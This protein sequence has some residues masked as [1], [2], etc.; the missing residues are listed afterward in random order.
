[1]RA[2]WVVL[3]FAACGD[4]GGTDPLIPDDGG[5]PECA[6]C[7]DALRRETDP[8]GAQLDDCTNDPTNTLEENVACFQQDGNCYSNA[9]LR[10]SSCHQQCGDASQAN[11]ESCTATCF[12]ARADCAEQALRASDRCLDVNDFNTCNARFQA[13][14]DACDAD[15]VACADT[16]KQRFRGG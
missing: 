12:T 2:L 5:T 11:V 1:V 10:A 15:A 13:D 16:C 6:P 9:L 14:I 3:A 7:A 4:E 8:C